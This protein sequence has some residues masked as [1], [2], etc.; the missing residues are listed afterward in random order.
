[1]RRSSRLESKAVKE[2]AE[3]DFSQRVAVNSSDGLK[4]IDAGSLGRGV[5]TTKT[6]DIGDYI[7]TYQGD[8]VS[9]KEAESRSFI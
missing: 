1:M 5:A 8:L 9:H 2:Q 6:F 4:Q 3:A 7:T